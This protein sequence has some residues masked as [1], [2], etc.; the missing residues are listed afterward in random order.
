MSP[1]EIEYDPESV[2]FTIDGETAIPI[3]RDDA[4]VGALEA[5]ASATVASLEAALN[6]YEEQ[7]AATVSYVFLADVPLAEFDP[8]LSPRQVWLGFLGGRLTVEVG[9]GLDRD[10]GP[11]MDV[12]ALL[13]PL[14]ERCG[15]E[16]TGGFRDDQ[17]GHLIEMHSLALIGDDRTVGELFNLA[18]DSQALIDAASGVGALTASAVRDLLA[19]GRAGVLLGQPES[20]WIDAKTEPHRI[21]GDASGIELGKD[22]AAFANTG[23]D[24]IIVWGLKTAKAAGGGDVLDVVRPFKRRASM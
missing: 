20:S 7:D 2:S 14:L 8:D 11:E 23:E 5:V 19:G 3:A 24:A 4:I 6:V 21:D 17:D 18:T 10:G 1:L 9:R 16:H 13:A 22:V 15:G 12:A